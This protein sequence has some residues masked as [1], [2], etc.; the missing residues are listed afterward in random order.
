M[1]YILYHYGVKGMKWG[2][3]KAQPSNSTGSKKR[4]PLSTGQKVAIGAAVTAG[5][6][7]TAYG[8]YTLSKAYGREISR[9]KDR[10]KRV[11]K[12]IATA[13]ETEQ[14]IFGAKAF[15]QAKYDSAYK[16]MIAKRT[17]DVFKMPVSKLVTPELDKQKRLIQSTAESVRKRI[18][19]S[20]FDMTGP[21]SFRTILARY[22]S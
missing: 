18:N 10:A 13:S 16:E 9:V 21:E 3:R 17:K 19:P 4:K 14:R 12:G 6:L 15:D 1:D 8:T 22:N 5:I 20:I 7:A 11:A 2:V